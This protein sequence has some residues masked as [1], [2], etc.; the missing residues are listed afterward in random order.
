MEEEEEEEKEKEEEKHEE[1][2]QRERKKIIGKGSQKPPATV[3]VLLHMS[4]DQRD[5]KVNSLPSSS[6]L[7][8]CHSV[9]PHA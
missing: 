3:T 8:H 9:V 6:Y 5:A 4:L 1:R 7:S 2:K